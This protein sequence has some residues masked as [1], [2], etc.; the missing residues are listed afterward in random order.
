[1]TLSK[2]LAQDFKH[3]RLGIVY[4]LRKH[5]RRKRILI[6]GVLAVLVPL[7]FHIIL[8]A[9]KA[10]LWKYP[11]QYAGAIFGG[12][13]LIIVSVALFGAD[14]ISSEFEK[15]TGLLL[16]ATPQRRTSILVAKYFGAAIIT[17]LVIALS[18][19]VSSLGLIAFYRELSIL[20]DILKSYFVALLYTFSVL[21]VAFLFSSIFKSSV[22]SILLTFFLLWLIMPTVSFVLMVAKI[23][24]WFVVTYYQELITMVFGGVT[25]HMAGSEHVGFE[26]S[27]P[28]FNTGIIIMT[29]YSVILFMLSVILA[30]RRGME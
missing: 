15:K 24:P 28:D 10:E 4:E 21:S 5:L 16:F 26:M 19:L 7:I 23:E 30:S 27:I 8:I 1:M 18:Y 2:E 29:C 11:E 13:V 14:S 9:T 22:L 20:S 25:Y 3:I 6:A 17:A 12:Y